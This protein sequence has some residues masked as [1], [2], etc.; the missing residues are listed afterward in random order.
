MNVHLKSRMFIVAL[1]VVVCA[2]A[3][4]PSARAFDEAALLAAP[5]PPEIP[6]GFTEQG[7]LI[8]AAAAGQLTLLD[9]NAPIAVPD[10]VELL[11]GLQYSTQG[12]PRQIL[13]LYLPKGN[14]KPLPLLIFIHGGGWTSG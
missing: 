6:T 12:D 2:A 8:L 7:Q 13:D 10:T 3:F 9:I 5:T 11:S 14:D 1:F 4:V